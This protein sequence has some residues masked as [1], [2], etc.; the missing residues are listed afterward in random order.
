MRSTF[1]P[2]P[3]SSIILETY[4][5]TAKTTFM[6]ANWQVNPTAL[7]AP[8]SLAKLTPG[9]LAGSQRL[10]PR[11]ASAS[12]SPGS[13]YGAGSCS[14]AARSRRPSLP[15]EWK[16]PAET[17][18]G[19]QRSEVI[20]YPRP[21]WR[22]L[23]PGLK[24]RRAV[25]PGCPGCPRKPLLLARGESS[26]SRRGGTWHQAGLEARTAEC[27]RGHYLPLTLS[28]VAS[29]GLREESWRDGSRPL[30]KVFAKK[31]SRFVLPR[32]IV[33]LTR[34]GQWGPN[35][36]SE[37]PWGMFW[38]RPQIR[39]PGGRGAESAAGTRR[40]REGPRVWRPGRPDSA[41]S[42]WAGTR[43]PRRWNFGQE[44]S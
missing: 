3:L 42:R 22:C 39:S 23:R 31:W 6:V 12:G 34:R 10:P 28:W 7:P 14:S 43:D 1:I 11:P 40:A 8:F 18:P 33:S 44:P 13:S 24:P 35:W 20:L 37:C 16:S 15:A 36:F 9:L 30:G 25:G 41:G 21:A 4:C 26:R 2:G 32:F 27:S 5:F 19:S 38:E 17:H 29:E